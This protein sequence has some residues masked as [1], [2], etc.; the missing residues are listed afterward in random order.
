MPAFN[1][2]K[3]DLFAH[4]IFRV[5]RIQVWIAPF[6]FPPPEILL[7]DLVPLHSFACSGFT[8]WHWWIAPSCFSS[9]GNPL[10][11]FGCLFT[12]VNLR[13]FD[14]PASGFSPSCE[15]LLILL[16]GHLSI[17]TFLALFSV[18]TMASCDARVL[19]LSFPRF[20]F[21]RGQISIPQSWCFTA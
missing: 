21:P 18:D 16:L 6:F 4:G 15:G 17:K 3:Y 7:I 12:G 2:A 11:W 5:H 20:T 19:N 1:F 9:V 13:R 10:E 14:N 8:G